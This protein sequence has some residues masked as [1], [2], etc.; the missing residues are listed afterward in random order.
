LNPIFQAALEV[1][2]FCREREWKF[3]FSPLLELKEAPEAAERLRV[4][5]GR[6][7]K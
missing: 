1:Q 6:A 3:C 4:L 7:S 2:A 5:L